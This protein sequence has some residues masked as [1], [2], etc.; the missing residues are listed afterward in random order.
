MLTYLNLYERERER[1][2]AIAA[3]KR[4]MTQEWI[5]LFLRRKVTPER[6]ASVVKSA[7]MHLLQNQTHANGIS[8][9]A[10]F[11]QNSHLHCSLTGPFRGKSM[12]HSA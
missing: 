8:C 12:Y 2:K 5:D 10:H 11:S 1:K 6:I 4:E 7:F 3:T 9:G